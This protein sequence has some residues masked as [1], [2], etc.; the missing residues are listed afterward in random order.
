MKIVFIT[1]IYKDE[2]KKEIER[3]KSEIGRLGFDHYKIYVHEGIADNRGYAYGINRGIEKGMKDGADVFVVFNADISLIGLKKQF[4][5]NGLTDYDLLGFAME[6]GAKNY[7]GGEID[8]WRLSGGLIDKKPT[9]QYVNVD[10]I[11]GSLMFIKRKVIEKTGLWDESY[12]FYYDEVDYCHRAK[13]AGFRIGI[14]TKHWY[15]HFELSQTNP[16]KDYFLAKNRLRFFWKYSN[17]WQKLYEIIRTP[18]TTL[19]YFPVFASLVAKSKFLTNLFSLNISSLLNKLFHFA[20]F[21]FLV[22]N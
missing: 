20:L 21:I 17:Y 5:I 9:K 10:F 7:Y 14:D 13:K 4:I 6:Q 18:K 12:F 8:R 19:E 1:N 15:K 3:L 16:R 11:S 2:E 22:K